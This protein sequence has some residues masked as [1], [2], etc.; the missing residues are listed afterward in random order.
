MRYEAPG[1]PDWA[2]VTADL[3][4]SVPVRLNRSWGLDHGTLVLD[5]KNLFKLLAPFFFG[6]KR[7]VKITWKKGWFMKKL[8]LGFLVVALVLFASACQQAPKETKIKVEGGSLTLDQLGQVQRALGTLM[9]E[10]A[11]RMTATNFA[12]KAGK[13]DLAGYELGE[14]REAMQTGEL[15]RPEHKSALKKFLDG[16]FTKIEKSVK[17]K[18]AA[19]FPTT[20]N[21]TV[22]ACNGCHK[23]SGVPFIEYALPPTFTGQPKI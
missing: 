8:L 15:T 11:Q 13:W 9:M 16:P 14:M 1:A 10:N 21:Q 19:G 12:A 23:T 17:D 18:D 22:D 2:E 6:N 7:V 4:H 3:I 5:C 20:F